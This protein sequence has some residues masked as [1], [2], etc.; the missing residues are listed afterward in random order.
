MNHQPFEEWLLS[1]EPLAQGQEADLRQHLQECPSCANLT[2]AWQAVAYEI[3]QTAQA[4]PAPGFSQRWQ[5]RLAEKHA[6]K[7]RRLAWWVMGLN[8]STALGIFLALNWNH[9]ANLS[10]SNLLVNGLYSLTLLFARIDSAEI[11]V[12][13]LFE[14]VNPL[15]PLAFISLTGSILSLLCLVW[16]ASLIKIYNFL[17]EYPKAV[18]PKANHEGL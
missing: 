13:M 18:N 6:Q 10:F 16:I 5:A 8:L 9:L 12:R 17:G 7:Q 15:I 11:L 4:A 3:K 2:T 1:K 14:E